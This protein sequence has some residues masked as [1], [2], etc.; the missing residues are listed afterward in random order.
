[1]L[2]NRAGI[3]RWRTTITPLLLAG[4]LCAC[5]PSTSTPTAVAEPGGNTVFSL[6]DI[7]RSRSGAQEK[8]GSSLFLAMIKHQQER[9]GVPDARLQGLQKYRFLQ[10]DSDGR[11]LIEI[12]L[13][14]GADRS[15]VE[16]QVVELDGQLTGTAPAV[17]DPVRAR[18]G[19]NFLE[20]LAEHPGVHFIREAPVATTHGSGFAEQ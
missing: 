11:L 2:L 3:I 5:S 12:L 8:I 15:T 7:Q 20:P 9:S 17:S 1:M 13:S 6:K 16:K 18:L 10:P 14:Q 4:G 19:L